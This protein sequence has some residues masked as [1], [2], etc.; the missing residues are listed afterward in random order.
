[1]GSGLVKVNLRGGTR[2]RE[3]HQLEAAAANLLALDFMLNE[4]LISNKALG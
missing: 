3:V 4:V 2:A 1:M